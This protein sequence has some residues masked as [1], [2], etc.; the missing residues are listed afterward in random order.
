MG[1]LANLLA[2]VAVGDGQGL[3]VD[4][5]GVRITGL[6]DVMAIQ[7][8]VDVGAANPRFAQ[9]YIIGQI[10]VARTGWKRIIARPRLPCRCSVMP[11][12]AA[13]RFPAHAVGMNRS[14][15]LYR[16]T[17]KRGLIFP[18]NTTDI[19][20]VLK[21]CGVKRGGGLA[22]QHITRYIRCHGSGEIAP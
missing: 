19:F 14:R 18:G 5:D 16:I 9:L 15:K 12:T 11:I 6:D 7:A 17:V 4:L 13:I 2:I 1:N 3:A 8:E 20:A 21:L 10:V 22:A